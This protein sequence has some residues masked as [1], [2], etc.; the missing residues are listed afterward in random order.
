MRYQPKT[1]RT[2]IVQLLNNGITELSNCQKPYT[3][4]PFVS[5]EDV[6]V[7]RECGQGESNNDQHG[8]LKNL[9]TV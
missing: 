3:F 9:N 6:I 1:K 4:F 8:R 5:F 7:G 2:D